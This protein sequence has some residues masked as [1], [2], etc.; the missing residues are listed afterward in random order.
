MKRIVVPPACLSSDKKSAILD[1]KE[2]H[3]VTR[4][5]RRKVGDELLLV[6]GSGHE[7]RGAIDELDRSTVRVRIV[8]RSAAISDEL[9]LPKVILLYGLA[10]GLKT[11]W[12]L[13]KCTELGVNALQP[14]ICQRSVVRPESAGE[15]KSR[16]W[17]T[18]IEQ[19]AR[20]SGRARFPE[21]LPVLEFSAALQR[22]KERLSTECAS[23]LIATPSGNPLE[24]EIRS[25]GETSSSSTIVI[26]VGPEGGFTEPEVALAEQLEFRSVRLGSLILRSETAAIAL[27]AVVNF[28][29]GRWK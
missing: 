11:E 28:G 13:Q 4:V 12:V 17:Q 23:Y 5:L 16:R 18:V 15:Y 21:L 22:T 26:A 19:A 10:K 7:Y 1:G 6:D 3:Y 20:Q 8:S 29:F 2:H 14:M 27:M 25:T 9:P 24:T